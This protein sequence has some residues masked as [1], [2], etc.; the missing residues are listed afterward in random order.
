METSVLLTNGDANG[1]VS[2]E[3]VLE[4]NG[5]EEEEGEERDSSS[6]SNKLDDSTEV[7]ATIVDELVEN[8]PNLQP[9]MENLNVLRKDCFLVFRCAS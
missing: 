2:S 7:V 3:D 9:D 5:Q 1:S 4:E 8:L 6:N